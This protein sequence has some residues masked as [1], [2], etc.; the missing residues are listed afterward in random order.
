MKAVA[1]CKGKLPQMT[2][3]FFHFFSPLFLFNI[4][5]HEVQIFKTP[6]LKKK[7]KPKTIPQ[8]ICHKTQNPQ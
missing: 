4:F 6:R 1:S 5:D 3:K 8:K 7:T 2:L